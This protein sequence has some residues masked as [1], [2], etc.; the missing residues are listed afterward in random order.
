MLKN[1]GTW[2]KKNIQGK[3]RRKIQAKNMGPKQRC[4][5]P[6]VQ[7]ITQTQYTI[8]EREEHNIPANK[9]TIYHKQTGYGSTSHGIRKHRHWLHSKDLG[10]KQNRSRFNDIASQTG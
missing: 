7:I 1:K 8:L 10:H 9:S 6:I 5:Q 4:P 2:Y 3:K